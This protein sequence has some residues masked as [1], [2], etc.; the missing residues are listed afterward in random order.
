MQ[1]R[2]KVIRAGKFLGAESG[3]SGIT[4]LARSASPQR[5]TAQQHGVAERKHVRRPRRFLGAAP[6]LYNA[7]LSGWPRKHE[8]ETEK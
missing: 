7:A 3:R 6:E 1:A 8:T 2:G 5:E 4:T